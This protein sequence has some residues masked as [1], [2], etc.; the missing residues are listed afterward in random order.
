MHDL[1]EKSH[2]FSLKV[3]TN[4]ISLAVLR[5]NKGQNFV[6]NSY[7]GKGKLSINDFEFQAGYVLLRKAIIEESR[8]ILLSRFLASQFSKSKAVLWNKP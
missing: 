4:D 5:K 8:A 1:R 3:Q 2:Q 7:S 6:W